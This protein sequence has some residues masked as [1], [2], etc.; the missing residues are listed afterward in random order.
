[1]WKAAVAD[2]DGRTAGAPGAFPNRGDMKSPIACVSLALAAAL[3][4]TACEGVTTAPM[5]M[6]RVEVEVT[7]QM[8]PSFTRKLPDAGDDLTRAIVD[9]VMT[10]A[11]LGLRFYPVLTKSYG[12]KDTRPEYQLAVEVTN[13]DVAV[14]RPVT[15]TNGG[16]PVAGTPWIRQV[17]CTVTTTI[18]KRRPTGPALMVGRSTGRGSVTATT[19]TDGS[20]HTAYTLTRTDDQSTTV[21]LL[22][23]D[24]MHATQKGLELALGQ[25]VKPVDRELGPRT[26][27]TATTT[28]AT[29]R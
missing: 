10:Q 26:V 11:D 9:M 23:I 21:S 5:G 7:V 3:A 12:P 28:A 14:D 22:H 19:T 17:D 18:S 13:L 15:S 20:D 27:T 24:L 2:G 16:P 6:P 29:P 4:L 1:M 8:D 25:L